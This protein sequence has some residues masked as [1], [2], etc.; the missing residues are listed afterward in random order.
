MQGRHLNR[1]NAAGPVIVMENGQ[2]YL[3]PIL[4]KRRRGANAQKHIGAE[5]QKREAQR[6]RRRVNELSA[7]SSDRVFPLESSFATTLHYLKLGV[8]MVASSD[9]MARTTWVTERLRPWENQ[10][11]VTSTS[12]MQFFSLCC[13]VTCCCG[14]RRCCLSGCRRVRVAGARGC[15]GFRIRRL[16]RITGM[17]RIV[18]GRNRWRRGVTCYA[19]Q[20]ADALG[21]NTAAAAAAAAARDKMNWIRFERPLHSQG[22]P[23]I[24][25]A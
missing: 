8:L 6:H 2:R 22:V 19:W 9:V 13:S 15:R 16:Q 24:C 1:K 25:R 17:R 20:R 14:R 10:L 4:A 5:A 18:K 11:R 21:W 12:V 23:S 7:A 3:N